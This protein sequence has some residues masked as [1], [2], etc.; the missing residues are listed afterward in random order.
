M[1]FIAAD[2]PAALAALLSLDACASAGLDPKQA[3]FVPCPEEYVQ[4]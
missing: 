2:L 3:I 4:E 1:P